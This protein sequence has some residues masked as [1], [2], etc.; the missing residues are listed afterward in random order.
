MADLWVGVG[1]RSG[2]S[3]GGAPAEPY[4]G[5]DFLQGLGGCGGILKDYICSSFVDVYLVLVCVLEFSNLANFTR[6][7]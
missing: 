3:A 2:D 5:I 4:R 1:L 7:C 6:I